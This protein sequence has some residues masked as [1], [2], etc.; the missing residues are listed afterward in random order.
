MGRDSKIEWTDHTANLW[1]GCSEVHCGCDNC[2]ARIIA[3]KLGCDIWGKDKPR[4][5]IGSVWQ[6]LSKWNKEAKA[7]GVIYRVFVNSMSDFFE[8]P[9]P[10]IE[11]PSLK[12]RAYFNAKYGLGEYE[13]TGHVR[14]RFFNAVK[15]YKNLRFQIL[16]KRPSNIYKYIP[17][18]WKTSPPDNVL[19]GTSPV[20]QKTYDTLVPQLLKVTGHKFLSVEPQLGPIDL[21]TVPGAGDLKWIIQ[22]GESGPQ[23]VRRPFD[24]AWADSLREQSASLGIPY[25]FKQIDRV[26]EI[27]DRLLVRQF[28]FSTK[29]KLQ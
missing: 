26:Q 9:M 24:L 29:S 11:N 16:T 5:Y 8:K 6:N 3:E 1:W 22:G 23:D 19:F 25:F 28:P 7:R 14:Q 17:E 10:L 20:D 12:S 4:K 18:S 27:P 13:D 2:Y 21:S 15:V